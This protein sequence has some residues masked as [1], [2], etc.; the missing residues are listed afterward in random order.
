ME[1]ETVKKGRKIGKR[2]RR[3]GEREKIRG[4]KRRERE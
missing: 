2:R 4:G 3:K 1:L